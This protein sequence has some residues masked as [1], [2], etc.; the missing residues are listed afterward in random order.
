MY[1]YKSVSVVVMIKASWWG[2]CYLKQLGRQCKRVSESSASLTVSVA[3]A[4]LEASK[5]RGPRGL[6]PQVQTPYSWGWETVRR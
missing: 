1:F 4:A 2:Q 3:D 5:G 6:L